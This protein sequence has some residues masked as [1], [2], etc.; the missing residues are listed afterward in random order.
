MVRQLS[1]LADD[2]SVPALVLVTHHV[3]EIPPGMTH[4]ALLR[5]AR[6]VAAGPVNEVL[7]NTAVSDAFGIDVVVHLSE[8]RWSARAMPR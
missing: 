3:E 7:T 4:A 1:A 8:G 5:D 6:M 2:P